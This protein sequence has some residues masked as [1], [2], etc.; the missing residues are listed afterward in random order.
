MNVHSALSLL[1]LNRGH[2]CVWNLLPVLRRCIFNLFV[3][4][5][6]G[7]SL[8]CIHHITSEAG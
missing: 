6:M 5:W 7:S 8:N 4:Y 2:S 3:F 1:L